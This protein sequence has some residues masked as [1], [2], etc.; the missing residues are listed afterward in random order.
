MRTK[1]RAQNPKKNHKGGIDRFICRE[2]ILNP[3]LFRFAVTRMQETQ[4]LLIIEDHAPAH[5]HHYH[6]KT[7]EDL[8]LKKIIWP[9]CSPELNPIQTIWSEMK[10]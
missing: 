8:G 3:L 9:S 4:E 7:Q 6:I 2:H 1:N 10:D 5:K